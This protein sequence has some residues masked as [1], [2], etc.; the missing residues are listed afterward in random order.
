M[1]G[2]Y[3]E[4]E[5]AFGVTGGFGGDDDLDGVPNG[6]EFLLGTNPQVPGGS[7]LTELV[8][9]NS[10]PNKIVGVN[11]TI[12]QE[13]ASDAHY[14][15]YASA[16]LKNWSLIASKDGAGPWSSFETASVME[17]APVNGGVSITVSETMPPGTA[18]RFHAEA[19]AP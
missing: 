4:W 10:P 17:A 1:P 9:V 12:P 18:P 13:P 19:E 7:A 6:I 15:L 11:F 8:P 3:A 5:S 16:N 14:R 2:T